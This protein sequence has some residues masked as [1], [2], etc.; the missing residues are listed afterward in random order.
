MNKIEFRIKVE[1]FKLVIT[2]NKKKKNY[3]TNLNNKNYCTIV[4]IINVAKNAISF[5]IIF[6]I[7]NILL[8]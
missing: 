8:K 3:I 6:K 1:K 2:F 4:K 5:L 7:S